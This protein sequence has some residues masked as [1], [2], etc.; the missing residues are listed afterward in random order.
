[1][2]EHLEHMFGGYLDGFHDGLI[3]LAWTETS[4]PMRTG[5][6]RSGTALMFGTDQIEE[7][8]TEAVRLNA[9]PMC[10]RVYV[11]AALRKPGIVP[12]ARA[13]RTPTCWR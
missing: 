1:M 13:A 12:S 5:A 4:S 3:E 7:L 10:N 11:G 8:I 2:R 6:T 9:Q